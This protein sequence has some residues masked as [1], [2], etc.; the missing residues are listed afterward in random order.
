MKRL[1]ILSALLIF[2]G[3]VKAQTLP[4]ETFFKQQDIRSATISPTGEY[5]AAVVEKEGKFRLVSM[6]LASRKVL[7]VMSLTNKR[8]IGT[9]NWANDERYFFNVIEQTGAFAQPRST[10]EV[11]ARNVD[12][13]REKAIVGAT[14]GIKGSTSHSYPIIVIDPL[15]DERKY[16]IVQQLKGDGFSN[17]F[18]LNVYNGKM[19]KQTS[20]KSLHAQVIADHNHVI[21]FSVGS[22]HDPKT[23]EHVTVIHYRASKDSDWELIQ[24]RGEKEGGIVPIAF[25]KDNKRVYVKQFDDTDKGIYLYDP[26]SKKMELVWKNNSNSNISGYVWNSDVRNRIPVGVRK[27]HGIPKNYYFDSSSKEA[28][29][30]QQLSATFA[31]EYVQIYNYTKDGKTA[32]L[33]VFSDRNPGELYKL[34]LEDN[35]LEFI[36]SYSPWIKREQMAKMNPFSFKTRD[37]LTIHGYLTLPNGKSKNLPLILNV[38]G[39]PYGIKDDWGFDPADQFLAN[40][41]YAV[42]KINFRGSGGYGKNFVYDNYLK[43][44]EE[45]QNDLTDATHWAISEGIA[46]KNR[47]CIYGVSYGGYAALMGAVKEPDLYKCAVPYAGVYDVAGLHKWGLYP[48]TTQGRKN[49]KKLWGDNQEFYDARSPMTYLNK[50]KAALFIVHGEKD[51]IADYQ[52]Y[53]VLTDALDDMGYPYEHVSQ[54]KEEHGFY[55]EKNNYELFN[56]LAI[57]FDKHIGQ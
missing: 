5:L 31:N 47:I 19:L 20:I 13:K 37:G 25:A 29:L 46:N 7:D 1:L 33:Q 53:E 48:R 51:I 57:F 10:G 54:A 39:G 52:H 11:L 28:K 9:V 34:N 14:S 41:G 36:L 55:L 4:V 24:V 44:G 38:H 45:M 42:M 21:R 12:G 50:L 49:L 30:H 23:N 8:G 22:K 35:K 3:G 6:E 26:E 2:I 17:I 56:K 40:R 43:E 32:L 16:A 27:D 15:V 18:K